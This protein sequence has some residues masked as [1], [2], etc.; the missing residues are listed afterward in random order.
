MSARAA[1]ATY[2][3]ADL[4]TLA[5][6]DVA[7]VVAAAEAGGAG[8]IQLRAKRLGAGA[9][10]D[11]VAECAAALAGTARLLIN[12]RVDVYLAAAAAGARI[13]GVHVGQSDLS[14]SDVR[15]IVGQGA[16]VGVSASTPREIA[17]IHALPAGTVDYI[18]A[19]AVRATPTKPDHPD[20]L[21]WAG[22][23]RACRAAREVPVV[24]IGGLGTGDAASAR[25]AG[26][27]GVAVVRAVCLA[28]DPRRAAADL[29]AEWRGAA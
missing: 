17:A 7:A 18:G 26:A 1:L 25:A 3:V 11:L 20:P 2:V 13:H 6:R 19:G 23:A 21:G 16:V 9:F 28:E 27:A 14:A 24:A 12:D 22:L 5:G 8:T 4:A 29:A 10:R 15:G